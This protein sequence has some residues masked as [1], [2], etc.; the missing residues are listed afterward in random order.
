MSSKQTTFKSCC[1]KIIC[2]GCIVAMTEE[3]LERG[4]EIGLCA[5]CRTPSS[6]LEDEEIQRTKKLMGA[7][8]AY[9]FHQLRSN[10]DATRHYKG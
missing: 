6:T 5:F 3:A 2:D 4:G 9:A 1:G 7:N 8:N 10:G